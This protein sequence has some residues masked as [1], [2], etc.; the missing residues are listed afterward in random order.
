VPLAGPGTRATVT[1]DSLA[2]RTL[3]A[4]VRTDSADYAF[5]PSSFPTT[6]IHL[7]RTVQ[8]TLSLEASGSLLPPGTPVDVTFTAR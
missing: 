5:P 6:E 1:A 2:G 7:L 4:V 3:T 8:V